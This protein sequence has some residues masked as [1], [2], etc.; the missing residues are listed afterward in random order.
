M[1]SPVMLKIEFNNYDLNNVD[2]VHLTL[3]SS[4]LQNMN[5]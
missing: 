1:G 4:I 3:G 2:V 5:K